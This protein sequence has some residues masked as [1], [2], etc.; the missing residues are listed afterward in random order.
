MTYTGGFYNETKGTLMS[1]KKT[2]NEDS[3]VLG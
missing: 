3:F 1:N 2:R